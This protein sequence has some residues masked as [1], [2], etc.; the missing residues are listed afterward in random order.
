MK[1]LHS[2]SLILAAA[3]VVAAPAPAQDA[4]SDPA[5]APTGA[6]PLVTLSIPAQELLKLAESGIGEDIQISY[7]NASTAPFN[8][9]AD[10]IVYMRDQGVAGDVLTAMLNRDKAIGNQY[11]NAPVAPAPVSPEPPPVDQ[12]TTSPPPTDVTS[13]EA[14]PD[15]APFYNDLAPYGTWVY[16]DGYGMAWQ[17]NAVVIDR[18][19]RPYCNG[20]HWIDSTAGWYW[21]S[22]Y[23]WGWAPF[24]YGRWL[25]HPTA[26]WVWFPDTTWGPGWVEW[27]DGSDAC[28][29]APL[30]WGAQC[31]P[32]VGFLYQGQYVDAAFDF[33]LGVDA[34]TFVSLGDF[35][36]HDYAHR[37]WDHDR[38]RQV[39]DRT[40]VI[41][42]HLVNSQNIV[43]NRGIEPQR[44]E[45]VSHV[46]MRKMEIRDGGPGVAGFN[47]RESAG[48]AFRRTLTAP[49]T[50]V[51]VS[52]QKF[53]EHSA[54]IRHESII[55]QARQ[56]AAAQNARRGI[57]QNEGV[58]PGQ[59]QPVQQFNRPENQQRQY[60]QPNQQ[61]QFIQPYQQNP[62]PSRGGGTRQDN[63]VHSSNG[64]SQPMGVAAIVRDTN[65]DPKPRGAAQPVTISRVEG[66][67]QPSGAPP[68]QNT[69]H[70]GGNAA[71]TFQRQTAAAPAVNNTATANS[72]GTP[73]RGFLQTAQG[74]S[75]HV[76]AAPASV[77]QVYA[78]KSA[79]QFNESR[80]AASSTPAAAQH[81]QPSGGQSGGQTRSQ[82]ASANGTNN[83]P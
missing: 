25:L 46:T 49:Q 17:P 58:A 78:P 9:S 5:L 42:D 57:Y 24:H 43:I 15:V 11:Q 74:T 4:S 8:M 40:V 61:R 79:S 65:P 44:I 23:S 16:L 56:G 35:A 26:G 38:A 66:V 7:V 63:P 22:Q 55:P 18:T 28:G 68:S 3:L 69:A 13:T 31:V 60:N 77:S 52:A 41:H 72:S 20:G 83:H 67:Q 54:S 73:A 45:A 47:A 51:I 62:A 81:S 21:Q 30:P 75:L 82:A 14:P 19:W 80:P 36:S 64:S 53:G 34:F 70:Q 50:P 48:V 1:T 12:P 59:N 33:G 39:F 10:A 71:M 2:I 32:G 76:S 29:W 37:R 27:R 6:V